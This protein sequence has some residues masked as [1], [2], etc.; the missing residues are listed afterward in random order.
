M[1]AE[2]ST[3]NISNQSKY[4]YLDN[5]NSP[6]D[7]KLLPPQA[8]IP[9]AEEIRDFLIKSVSKNGGHLSSNLGVVE[10]SIALHR[11]FDTPTDHIIFDVGHQCYVHKILTGRKE[12]F[13]QLRQPGGLSGFTKIEESEHDCFGAGHSST[14]ISA[15]LGFAE[16]EKLKGNSA[17]TVAVVGDGAFTG[18]M[19]HE[20]LNNCRKNL[21][22]IIV[23]NENEMSISKN[24]GL[25]A[26]N[27]SKLRSR[28]GYF[29]AKHFTG[30]V[31][32]KIP[33]VGKYIFR[34]VLRIKKA[35]K[36]F[37]Y[38]SNY[39]E[40]LG[41]YYL[42]PVDGNDYES[43]EKILIQAKKMG[44]NV[45]IHLK[46]KKGKGYEPAEQEP[47]KYH[48]VPP[49]DAKPYANTLSE[50]FG[51]ILTE[52][53]RDDSKI[54]AITAAM[55][56]GTGLIPFKEAHPDRFYD[57]GIAEEH[58]VTFGAGL[59]AAGMRPA[60]AIYSTFLQRAYDNIIHDV[61]LQKLP[62][63]LCIDR[64]GLNSKDGP[65]HHGIFDVAF[66]SQIP[67]IT[68]YTPVTV[69][70]LHRAM[71]S[72][73]YSGLPSAIRYA[74]VC[75]NARIVR[76]FY[77]DKDIQRKPTV[78]SDFCVGDDLSAVIVTYGKIVEEAVKASDCLKTDNINSGVV[79]LE[80]L[81]PYDKLCNDIMQI[82]PSTVKVIIFLEE[83]IKNGGAG[84][85][86]RDMMMENARMNNVTIDVLAI[87]DS[88]AVQKK[89][90]TAYESAGISRK[91]IV[92]RVKEM[93][94]NM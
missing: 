48:G 40:D 39:F 13:E 84:M 10:L 36:N 38:G 73:F 21:R 66:L 74:N 1:A 44:E 56:D 92:F 82:I 25:F 88:F 78:L 23:L 49:V 4:V 19:I 51:K 90:E 37:M 62:V 34:G 3:E 29:K 26:K 65:T 9:L 30:R 86:L 69:E 53:A 89:G 80:Y 2:R 14:S 76:D 6:R 93:L 15:A 17:Y 45:L 5:I 75:E 81:K 28:P 85:I 20:A 46:T 35:F 41:L 27:L 91:H 59:A 63:T 77:S 33:F 43:V 55:A 72:A 22:L 7:L 79:L 60:V 31:L 8:M 12:A 87:D 52:L 71:I 50:E 70:G 24:I 32:K 11:V 58:A 68:I 94:N 67:N 54:C 18:G 64:S 16:A 47:G 57:V 83:G 61:A 42:G